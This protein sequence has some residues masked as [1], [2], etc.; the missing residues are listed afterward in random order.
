[1]A[2]AWLKSVTSGM[3][4]ED[5]RRL[6][7]LEVVL[8]SSATRHSFDVLLGA[9]PARAADIVA[10]AIKRLALGGQATK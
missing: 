6:V 4:T 3:D 8:T 10:W 7:E 1:M 5:R 2:E 9:S